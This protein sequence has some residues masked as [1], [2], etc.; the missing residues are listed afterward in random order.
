MGRFPGVAI[1]VLQGFVN[2]SRALEGASIGSRAVRPVSRSSG[3][4]DV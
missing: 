2:F 3:G 1:M 4:S